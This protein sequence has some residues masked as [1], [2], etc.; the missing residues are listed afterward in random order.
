MQFVE[1]NPR[2]REPLARLGLGAPGDFLALG[3][4]IWCGHP[5]RHVARV[6]LGELGG[7]FLKREHRIRRRDR[8][9]NAWAGFGFVS[10]S[11]RE[12]LLLR[13]LAAVGIG[14]PEPLA[15]GEEGG[16]AFLLLR[17][18]PGCRDLRAFL[19]ETPVSRRGEV[20][21]CLGAELAR[22]HAAEFDHPDLYSKHVL[23]G[24]VGSRFVFHFLDWQRSRRGRPSWAA[25]WRD[26]AALDATL[27]DELV[28]PRERV[29]SLREYLRG[30]ADAGPVPPLGEALRAICKCSTRLLRRRRIREL[31]QPPLAAGVQNL[32]WLDGEALCVTREFQAELQGRVPPSLRLCTLREAAAP[33]LER[34]EVPREGGRSGLLVRRGASRPFAW[35]W[36]WLRRRPLTSPELQQAGILFRLQRYGVVTPRLLA[37]GQRSSPPWRTASFLLTEP[38]GGA[39]PLAAWLAENEDRVE[40]TTVL[41][42]AGDVLRRIHDAGCSLAPGATPEEI[43]QVEAASGGGVHIVVGDV[44]GL[45][46]RHRLPRAASARELAS[47]LRGLAG[48]CSRMDRLRL[49]LGYVQAERGEAG[50]R[51]TSSK[52]KR[53]RLPSLA[54]RA[55]MFRPRS[56]TVAPAPA[57]QDLRRLAR[58]TAA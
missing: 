5:D 7:A 26:L 45:R 29:A 11:Y 4:V 43:L 40:R 16:R 13:E 20:A 58:S 15:A 44:D 10:K 48:L 55:C 36:N 54:L 49:L 38:R 22:L 24:T 30:S 14:C 31:R 33:S 50:G 32:I 19:R 37:V 39:V 9:A 53:G 56:A 3:G 2:C 41:R 27:A 46:K 47:V 8:V 6:T 34:R 17:E 25:R 28:T 52:R 57:C 1:V 51:D 12:F 18:L 21:V 35:L 42:D 23:V